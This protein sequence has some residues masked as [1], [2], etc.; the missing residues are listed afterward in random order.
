[1]KHAMLNMSNVNK[2]HRPDCEIDVYAIARDGEAQTLL[3]PGFPL[4]VL[5]SL[6][7]C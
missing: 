3:T 2:L 7:H 4:H 5:L 1:M 6:R